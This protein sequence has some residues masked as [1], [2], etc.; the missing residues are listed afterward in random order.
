MNP[1]LYQINGVLPADQYL[2]GQY[3]WP[4]AVQLTSALLDCQSPPSSGT[5]ILT[6]EVGGVLQ[7]FQFTIPS[8]VGGMVVPRSMN[9]LVPANT[10]VRWLATFANAPEDTATQLA[11][12]LQAVPQSTSQVAAIQPKLTVQWVNGR[13]RL[14]LFNYDANT[15]T[16]T[17]TSPGISTGRATLTQSGNTQLTISIGMSL[18]QTEV[19]NVSGM[20]FFAPAFIAIGG[21]A[22]GQTPRLLFNVDNVTVATLAT[23]GLRVVELSEDDPPVL[24]PSDAGFYSRFEFYSSGVLTAV[25]NGQGLTALD[26]EEFS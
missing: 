25:L 7:S 9:V 11:I 19:L 23:D 8:G 5:L 20:Q 3:Q 15:R 17:E 14:T 16:F 2:P 4:Y 22:S 1:V 26:L 12:M 10:P 13:E 6:L 18:P 24:A 21:V